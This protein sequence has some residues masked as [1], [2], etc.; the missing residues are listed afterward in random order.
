MKRFLVVLD[1]IVVIMF[2]NL[3]Y[4]RLTV[5]M[6]SVEI[7]IVYLF[8]MVTFFLTTIQSIL[9]RIYFKNIMY[10]VLLLFSI[11]LLLG[12][13]IPLNTPNSEVFYFAFYVVLSLYV[14][15]NNIYNYYNS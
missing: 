4:L 12:L 9:Y 14:S 6:N 13:F 1:V 7:L 10:T 15:M 2:V 8:V 5:A 11:Y 3:L